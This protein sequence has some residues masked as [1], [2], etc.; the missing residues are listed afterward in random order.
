MVFKTAFRTRLGSKMK[1]NSLSGSEE[2]EKCNS[3]S[4]S[5][6]EICKIHGFLNAWHFRIRLFLI[7]KLDSLAGL[8][9]ISSAGVGFGTVI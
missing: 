1:H 3:I 6:R 4:R 7:L 5:T 8:F 2:G 9:N